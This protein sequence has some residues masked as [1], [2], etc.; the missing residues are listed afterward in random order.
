[1]P[2]RPSSQACWSSCCVVL[3]VMVVWAGWHGM[4]IHFSSNSY[5]SLSMVS[6]ASLSRTALKC[7]TFAEGSFCWRCARSYSSCAQSDTRNSICGS[8]NVGALPPQL[9]HCLGF[10]AV[11]QNGAIVE[12]LAAALQ[13]SND[14]LQKAFITLRFRRQLLLQ[15][16]ATC[17]VPDNMD[18]YLTQAILQDRTWEPSV[19]TPPDS[20]DLPPPAMEQPPMRHLN[21]TVRCIAVNT[22][23]NQQLPARAIQTPKIISRSCSACRHFP[24]DT[25]AKVLPS[26]TNIHYSSKFVP[27]TPPAVW[28]ASCTTPSGFN[29][30]QMALWDHTWAPCY[31]LPPAWVG[32]ASVTNHAPSR[33]HLNINSRCQVVSADA[34]A[35]AAA[36]QPPNYPLSCSTCRHFTCDTCYPAGN[37]SASISYSSH[38][39]HLQQM[40][41]ASSANQTFAAA[42]WKLVKSWLLPSAQGPVRATIQRY[43]WPQGVY[44]APQSNTGLGRL[45]GVVCRSVWQQQ[46]Q[47][48]WQ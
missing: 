38:Q 13:S 8:I 42:V 33:P 47:P 15:D 41:L 25:C 28:T 2:I 21:G 34:T 12:G 20:G 43:I 32:Y 29:I 46:R 7:Q 1:M 3:A 30:T 9:S 22:N 16:F 14:P 23:S 36:N 4:K 19:M 44:P 5:E 48:H 18:E 11:R 45:K 6:R 39:Q 27:P 10:R 17:P 24:C 35:P 26:S 31:K 37:A 40:L